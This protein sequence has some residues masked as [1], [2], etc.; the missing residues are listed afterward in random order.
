MQLYS[1]V[2]MMHMVQPEIERFMFMS[3]K[4][5]TLVYVFVANHVECHHG[6]FYGL[7][8]I[9]TLLEAWHIY[10]L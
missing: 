2:R 3:I 1:V 5:S 7:V 10:M 9:L 4:G 8:S 6:Y